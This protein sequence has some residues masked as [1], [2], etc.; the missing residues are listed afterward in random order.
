[1]QYQSI[2]CVL[3]CVL[4]EDEFLFQSKIILY[5][6][7]LP[8]AFHDYISTTTVIPSVL[9]QKKIINQCQ[10]QSRIFFVTINSNIVFHSIWIVIQ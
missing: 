5:I 2:G 1:M 4:Y 10:P 9:Q 3:S 8:T 6:T 7:E